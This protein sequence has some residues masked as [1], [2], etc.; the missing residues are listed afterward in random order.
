[1]TSEE[2]EC[3]QGDNLVFSF[4]TEIETKYVVVLMKRKHLRPK[5]KK[6]KKRNYTQDV[7][8]YFPFNE[9]I[10]SRKI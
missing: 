4:I 10:C 2:E 1:M 8:K 6:K 5:R 3:E 9:I 7:E